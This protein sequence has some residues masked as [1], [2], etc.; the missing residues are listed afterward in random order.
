MLFVARLPL[1][2][3]P[4][5]LCFLL[6]R[7]PQPHGPRAALRTWYPPWG[8]RPPVLEILLRGTFCCEKQDFGVKSI[9]KPMLLAAASQQAGNGHPS[10]GDGGDGEPVPICGESGAGPCRRG[11]SWQPQ[12]PSTALEEGQE[13]ASGMLWA[14]CGL[15]SLLGNTLLL[16]YRG[17]V[18]QQGETPR[19]SNLPAPLNT[20]PH[21]IKAPQREVVLG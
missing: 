16:I 6:R 7:C 14:P 4:F 10:C 8:P 2:T 3:Q 9:P 17:L 19:S 18:C 20:K 21:G 1:V 5:L 12:G 11:V 15:Q 13:A